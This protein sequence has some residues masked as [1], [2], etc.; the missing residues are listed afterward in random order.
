MRK[1]TLVKVRIF[2]KL[3]YFIYFLKFSLEILVLDKAV[4][5]NLDGLELTSFHF[6]IVDLNTKH[7][8][9]I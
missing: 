8:A 3:I 5:T 7:D 9:V 6:D 2:V 1:F 4:V